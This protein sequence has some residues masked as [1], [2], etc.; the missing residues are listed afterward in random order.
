[1]FI[2][3]AFRCEKLEPAFDLQRN[4]ETGT[5]LSAIFDFDI[6]ERL[7]VSER[8]L[9][10]RA[11]SVQ[12]NARVIVKTSNKEFPSFQEISQF[13][14]EYAMARRCS[15]AG[16]VRPISLQ[17]TAG[18]WIMIQQDIDA[19]SL[20]H[21]LS[22]VRST[23]DEQPP[24]TALP[25]D[26]FFE[27]ALQLCEVLEVVHG[28]GIVHKDINPA[29]LVWNG[30]L[31]RLQLID[32]GIACEL[33]Q[34][35][36]CIDHPQHLEGSLR[37]MAP[38]QT[39]RMNRIVDYRADYYAVGATFYELLSGRPPFMATDAMELVH[40]HIAKEPDWSLA[41]F[42]CLPG[43][44][45]AVVQR[46]LEKNAEGR[47]QTVHALRQDLQICRAASMTSVMATG[48]ALPNSLSEPD[49]KLL[50]PQKLYGR[51]WEI[52]ALMAAFARSSNGSSEMLLVGGHSGIG[53]TTLIN[54]VHKPIVA[55]RGCFISGKFDQYQRDVPYAPLI[56]A[57]KGLIRQLSSEPQARVT[58]WAGCLRDALGINLGVIVELIPELTLIVGACAPVQSLPPVESQNR[59]NHT[60]R[61]FVTVF[62]TAAHPLV[63]F[64]DDLQWVDEPT[65]RMIDFLMQQSGELHLLIIGAY[66]ENEVGSVH[67][68]MALRNRLG[69]AGVPVTTLIL[70]PLTLAQ[71]ADVTA[72]TFNT[73]SADCASLTRLC[74]EKTGGNPF[75]LNQFLH[76]IHDAG[77]LR[78]R[79]EQGEWTW[80]MA[81]LESTDYTNNVV[82]L[83]LGKIQRLPSQTQQLLQIAAAIG[84]RFDLEV[85]SVVAGKTSVQIQN[86]LWPAL[87]AGLIHAVTQEHKSIAPSAPVLQVGY[88]FLHDRV[89]QTAY[90][91]SNEIERG[92]NHLRIGRQLYQHAAADTL[93]EQL[94]P[95]VE[96]LNAGRKW[97]TESA[98][99]V[100]LARLNLRAA[101]KVRGSAAFIAALRYVHIGIELLPAEA[102]QQQ[103]ELMLDLQLGCAEMAY[104]C[105]DFAAAEAIYPVVFENCNTVHDKIRC[106][107]IQ[108]YQY[109][110][111]GRL[112][113]AIVILRRG[114]DLLGFLIPVEISALKSAIDSTFVEIE[115]QLGRR[116]T[117]MLVKA[118]LD[119]P[120][121]QDPVS[122]AAMQ[123]MQALWT[124]GY[125]AGQQDLSLTLVLYMTRLSLQEGTSD[126]TPVAYVAYAY[127]MMS[128][129]QDGARSH[130]FGAMA[131][132]LANRR[133]NLQARSLTGLMFATMINHWTQPLQ[134]CDSLYDDAFDNALDSGDFV[135]VG[136]VAAVRATDRLI[137]GQYLPDL[138][139]ASLQDLMMMR[140]NSQ[141]DLADCLIAAAVQPIRCLMGQ[142]SH[143]DSYD[144]KDFSESAFLARH[145]GSRLYHAYFL[146]GK[147]RNAYFFDTVDAELLA[148]QMEVVTQMMRGQAKVPETTFYTALIWIRGLYRNPQ[149][150]DAATLLARIKALQLQLATWALLGVANI[151][152]KHLLVQAELARYR[153]D[154]PL[155]MGCYQQAIEA[156]HATGYINI[157]GLAN[158]LCGEF[159][160]EQQQQ[161][162]AEVFLN[163]AVARYRQWGADGKA[164]QLCQR[165]VRLPSLGHGS[166][167][168]RPV[169]VGASTLSGTTV[170]NASLDLE[171]IVKAS[172]AL[173]NAIGL[174]N[175]LQR[176]IAV[177]TE[178]S[179]AQI[180]RLLLL[181]DT[182]W[183]LEAETADAAAAMPERRYISLDAATDPR[184]P[185]AL[186]RYVAR[187]GNE[188]IEDSIV[189]SP[190][191]G[192]DPYVLARRPRSVMC[193]PIKQAGQV[194]GLLY[195][196]NN[197]L[198]GSFTS[199]SIEFLRVMGAQAMISISHARL[200]DSLE[201]RVAERTSQLEDANRKLAT[202]S[203]TDGLTGLPN[204][205]HFD[206]QLASEWARASRNLLPLTMI[207]IDVDHFKKYNDCYGHQDGDE[208]L[209][210]VAHA[211]QEGMR[212]ATDLAA[213]FGGE[214][215]AILLP[216]TDAALAVQIAEML[217]GA[218][219]RLAMPHSQSSLGLVTVSI[220]VAVAEHGRE[221]DAESLV[222][223]ADDA[224]YRAK[225]AGRNCVVLMQD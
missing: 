102:G 93:E 58:E 155:A 181:D 192:S 135:H 55:R 182:G 14:R 25:L 125:Y 16:V 79:L 35:I 221:H 33:E 4:P 188:I 133:H 21:L 27:I 177:V 117:G 99:R 5:S 223:A 41:Q 69:E 82:D 174:N 61:A 197:L 70:N 7:H 168:E 204:R 37:Y 15:H 105:G 23:I 30:T 96:Q 208:C 159:W 72:D 206:Q 75:F 160:L 12:E 134:S 83:M 9:V 104:L 92:Q 53:K 165:H 109:Q 1:M 80:D 137:L 84:N 122:L 173:S 215:F 124:A 184:F 78:Y 149:R 11:W 66:R 225:N 217:R 94:I 139:Q 131:L 167:R 180:A 202:L 19:L 218:I 178:N 3:R 46:L 142:V 56:E 28:H 120:A 191:F 214:E 40:C 108:A 8:S 147:I 42:E 203:A 26:D 31:R 140:A 200:H 151:S 43:S 49:G 52:D 63:I 2:L 91:V 179:G 20:N 54:A 152:S 64:L 211:L 89:Q 103:P 193:L 38:E 45:L 196:E 112:P 118:L 130:R 48:E 171:S 150:T 207:M 106:I 6:I 90:A 100:Q 172:H 77:H 201:Q 34:E 126:F 170:V 153:Q 113:D 128:R 98:E 18:R 143:N 116:E 224:L 158:E 164:V 86:L 199:G 190:R 157:Q 129:T 110:L 175:V 145:S 67:P 210:R 154:V 148:D 216:N 114:L 73:A 194:C 195:F 163:D 144:D 10:H 101:M 76:T 65:L 24:S 121:M 74:H 219:E 62:S 71:V 36:P 138:L 222:R 87:Q 59:L 123:M 213:R 198:D 169:G 127:F 136:I 166:V 47:Y 146:Q 39:G 85:L 44:L 32:F 88:R 183:C 60:F 185:L 141:N 176:L 115:R 13:K 51:A 187:S 17:Q 81:A 97:M 119:A 107:A 186:L 132:E 68:L 95:I 189:N 209:K 156:A 212:R 50:V 29:N 162:V 220:G 111:Q 57:F 161:R 205:R 22:A